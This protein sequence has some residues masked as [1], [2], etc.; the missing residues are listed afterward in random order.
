MSSPTADVACC[1]EV[2]RAVVVQPVATGAAGSWRLQ[3]FIRGWQEGRY[4]LLDARDDAVPTF[5]RSEMTCAVRFLYQGS[6]CGFRA[7]I[8]DLGPG[9][10]MRMAWPTEMSFAQIR[11]HERVDVAIPCTAGVE[12]VDPVEATITDLSLGGC[13][14]ETH[15]EVKKDDVL[16]LTAILPDGSNVE[17]C[18]VT[19]RNVV[20]VGDHHAAGC[21][22]NPDQDDVLR[23]LKF[24]VTTTLERQRGQA[25]SRPRVLIMERNA[26]VGKF[27]QDWFEER[28]CQGIVCT[29]AVDG[30]FLLRMSP[31]RRGT[32]QCD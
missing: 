24:Y 30:V 5:V 14:V 28:G 16:L 6:A 22:F 23:D 9:T 31:P 3:G 25:P 19:V 26:L 11:R 20:N 10:I 13:R 29:D 21:V 27:L 32:R 15:K 7:A 1:L 12:G 18:R 2:G 17:G 4:V 8:L